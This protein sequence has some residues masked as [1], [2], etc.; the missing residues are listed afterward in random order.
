MKYRQLGRSELNISL[1]GLGTMTWGEQNTQAEAFEQMDMARDY[2]INFFDVAEMYPVPPR[3]ETVHAT[4]TILGNWLE[5]RGCRDDIVL[6]T[7]VTGRSDRNSGVGHIRDGARLNREHIRTAIEGS[8]KRLKTDYLDLYQVHWPERQTNFFGKLDYPYGGDDGISIE[9]TLAAL[10]ELVTEGKVRHIGI[11]NESAWG[12]H[13]YLRVSIE[14]NYPRIVSIQNPY[15]LLNRSF[16]VGMSEMSL[17]ED[18]SLLAY[19]PLAFGV[20]SGKYIGGARPSGARLTLFD[21][22]TRYFNANSDAATESYANIAREHGL[23]MAQMCLAWINMQ[24]HVASNII[25]A[26]NLSQ[27]KTNIESV[28]L[29]LSETVLSEIN[30]VHAQYPN[31][32]P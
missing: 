21:R 28:D 29:E 27:L 17:R 32:A 22:F 1:I 18:V 31:P 13:E 11:S 2:K 9:E 15:N 23:D 4:E 19:S 6:A 16:D 14:R 8:L 25:G 24:P 30:A 7:K 3:P 12:I 10:S 26:T 20:L 5:A